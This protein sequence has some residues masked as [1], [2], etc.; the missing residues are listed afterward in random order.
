M[1]LIAIVIYRKGKVAVLFDEHLYRTR[2]DTFD[3]RYTNGIG[4]IVEF[5]FFTS[6]ARIT[7]TVDNANLIIIKTRLDTVVYQLVTK[8]GGG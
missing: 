8:D 7:V 6:W 3:T 1:K 5:S 4:R 2:L